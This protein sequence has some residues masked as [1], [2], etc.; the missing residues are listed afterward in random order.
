ME[1]DA[2]VCE[3]ARTY[4]V[5]SNCSSL[6]SKGCLPKDLRVGAT[7]PSVASVALDRTLA[8]CEKRGVNT[9]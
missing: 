9:S 5:S 1:P 7:F 3:T 6:F 4:G 8:F 2:L